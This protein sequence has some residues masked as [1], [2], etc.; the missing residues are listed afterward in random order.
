VAQFP[1]VETLDCPSCG[2]KGVS[3][4]FERLEFD[5][6]PPSASVRLAATVPVNT[7]PDCG[8]S[9][10]GERA[11]ELMH[12]AVCRHLG[13]MPP[14][15]VRSI[16]DRLGLSR[17]AFAELTQL[18][19]ASLAR[20]EGGLLVQNPA[21][22]QFLHLLRFEDNVARLRSRKESSDEANASESERAEFPRFRALEDQQ[23]IRRVAASFSLRI[24]ASV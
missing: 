22:D 23:S 7:C 1:G 5:Y 4:H 3:A 11:E 20:W 8:F 15:E 9:V 6:G 13:V 17:A 24:C 14:R 12:E 2:H 16:R 19:E 10:S 18:G 21:N